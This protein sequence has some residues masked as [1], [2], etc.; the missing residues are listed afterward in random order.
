MIDKTLINGLNFHARELAEK[1]KDK[2]RKSP[3]LKYYNSLDDIQLVEIDTAFYP[4][5]ARTLDRGL[6]K[7]LVGGFFVN[8]GKERMRKNF[9]ISEVIYANSLVERTVIEYVMGDFVYDNPVKMY[10]AV[11]LISDIS[12]FFI[13]GCFYLTK[14]FLEETYV[15]MNKQ[16]VLSEEMLKKYFR[17]DF[18]FKK[19]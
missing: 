2:I 13:L 17:D 5:L 11:G 1:W 8:I 18:F 12:E 10:S 14:G 15:N 6:D 19:N 9:P 16:N 7:S 4:L 3:Q